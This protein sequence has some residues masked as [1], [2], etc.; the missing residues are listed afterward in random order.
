MTEHVSIQAHCTDHWIKPKLV[1]LFFVRHLE[2]QGLWRLSGWRHYRPSNKTSVNIALGATAASSTCLN[3]M[4]GCLQ[5]RFLVYIHW[6]SMLST[7]VLASFSRIGFKEMHSLHHSKP[8]ECSELNTRQ[9]GPCS[10]RCQSDIHWRQH[11][12]Q[13]PPLPSKQERWEG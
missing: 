10:P 5:H 11:Q 2:E 9:G 13:T 8:Y 1:T 7:V 6:P 12:K 4:A 3:P